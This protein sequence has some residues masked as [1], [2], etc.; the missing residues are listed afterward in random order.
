MLEGSL[1][2][3]WA[4]YIPDIQEDLGLSDGQLGTAS[5]LMFLGTVLATN[6]AGWLTKHYGSKISTFIGG[7]CFGLTLP[8]VG[9]A[10]NFLFLCCAMFLYGYSM[11]ILDGK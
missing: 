1:M 5:L 8:L 4:C 3:L 9:L 2:G 11:G 10:P 6:G 7:I